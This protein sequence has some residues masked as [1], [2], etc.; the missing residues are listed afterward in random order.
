PE[1]SVDEDAPAPSLVRDVG[2]AG[3]VGWTDS[4]ASAE[5]MHA[6]GHGRPS[7]EQCRA[8]PRP[9]CG[10]SSP[11]PLRDACVVTMSPVSRGAVYRTRGRITGGLF[12]NRGGAIG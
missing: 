1:A 9:S 10:P 8:D 2:A 12:I 7:P 6:G 4:I 5:P 3:Q 11:A